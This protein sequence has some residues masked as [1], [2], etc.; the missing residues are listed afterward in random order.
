MG[1]DPALKVEPS[2]IISA[3]IANSQGVPL[4]RTRPEFKP[5]RLALQ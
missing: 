1:V 3:V 4:H 2:H 5:L